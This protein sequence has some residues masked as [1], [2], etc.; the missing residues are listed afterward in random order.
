MNVISS[1]ETGEIECIFG[2]H[3]GYWWFGA[4]STRASVATMLQTRQCV[5]GSVFMG[6]ISMAEQNVQHFADNIFKY[7]FLEENLCNLISAIT[8]FCS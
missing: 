7:I 8:K 5:P 4:F 6:Y 1:Y 3:C 2:Q